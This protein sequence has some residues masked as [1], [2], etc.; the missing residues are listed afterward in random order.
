MFN[1]EDRSDDDD[2]VTFCLFM[3][4]LWVLFGEGRKD[5][6]PP[7]Q[8]SPSFRILT[9]SFQDRRSIITEKL[10]SLWLHSQFYVS[11]F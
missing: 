1:T 3:T 9:P 4:Q 11:V 7:N 8:P 10:R 5:H 6:Q 2:A